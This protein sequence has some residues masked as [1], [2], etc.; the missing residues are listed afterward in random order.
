MTVRSA[1]EMVAEA[2]AAVDS[3][4]ATQAVALAGDPGVV[5]VDVREASEREK[6]GAVRGAVNAPRAFLEFLADPASERH[7]PPLSPDNRLV[8]FC[9]SGGRSALAAKTLK[10]MGFKNVAHVMGGFPAWTQAGGP[11]DKQA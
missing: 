8:L 1:K 9:A 11:V 3:L 10:D 5:F 2:N 4:T 7:L 6:T